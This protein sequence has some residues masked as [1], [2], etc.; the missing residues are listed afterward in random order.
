MPPENME[1]SKWRL[2]LIRAG[3]YISKKD[4][5]KGRAPVRNQRSTPLFSVDRVE[6]SIYWKKSGGAKRAIV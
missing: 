6:I 5:R 1:I 4:E 2:S 3:C